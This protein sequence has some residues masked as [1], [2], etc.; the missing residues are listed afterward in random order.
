MGLLPR[1]GTGGADMAGATFYVQ[2]C[3]VCG[4]HLEVRIQ[5]L[6]KQVSCVHCGGGFVAS[7]PRQNGAQARKVESDLMGRADRLLDQAR[8]SLK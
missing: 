3:P 2:T 4:R 1:P 7:H 8:N 5:Y 6:G